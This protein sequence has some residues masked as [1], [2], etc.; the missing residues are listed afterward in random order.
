MAYP[1]STDQIAQYFEIIGVPQYGA[2][3][4]S[5]VVASFFGPF[6]EAYSFSQ[7]ITEIN[8]RIAALTSAQCTRVT[9]HLTRWDTIGGTS[10]IRIS[11]GTSGAEGTLVDY[12]A[13]REEIRIALAKIIGF[14]CPDGGWLNQAQN[15]ITR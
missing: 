3:S 9:T 8:T 1:L 13:E 11:K 4:N 7:L 6:F 12:P 10:Q 5:R 14:K 2:A 15:V